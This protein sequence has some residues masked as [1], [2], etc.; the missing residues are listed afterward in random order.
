VKAMTET[1][2]PV[3]SSIALFASAVVSSGVSFL[4]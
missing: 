3:V 1:P 2:M 4:T